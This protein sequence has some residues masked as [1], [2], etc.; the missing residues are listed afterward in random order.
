MVWRE[1]EPGTALTVRSESSE[2]RVDVDH[3]LPA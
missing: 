1:I 3:F 2:T